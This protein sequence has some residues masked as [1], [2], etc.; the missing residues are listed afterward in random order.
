MSTNVPASRPEHLPAPRVSRSL[1]VTG[2]AWLGLFG[3]LGTTAVAWFALRAHFTMTSVGALG[4]GL[5][6]VAA[7]W[8]LRHR[9]E[10]ARQSIIGVQL[11]GFV[12]V[13][14]RILSPLSGA[15][16][17]TNLPREV[18]EQAIHVARANAIESLVIA[19]LFGGYT[20]WKLNTRRV[21]E[22]FAEQ[23]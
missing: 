6:A 15:T 18:R 16:I 10:W 17:P 14:V 11:Y 13:I 12:L 22:E 3:G 21:R 23:D 19:L 20:I 8:G 1:F 7:S 9:R 5:M 4:G 2:M